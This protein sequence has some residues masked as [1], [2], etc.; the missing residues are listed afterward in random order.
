MFVRTLNFFFL[1]E[2]GREDPDSTKS[3]PSSAHQ[4]NAILMVFSWQG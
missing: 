1:V 3:R 4:Q 2:E